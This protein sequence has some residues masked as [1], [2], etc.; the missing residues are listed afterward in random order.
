MLP[1]HSASLGLA[2]FHVLSI[3]RDARAAA[4]ET[5]AAAADTNQAAVADYTSAADRAAPRRDPDKLGPP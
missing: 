4:A 2:R 1:G 3:P 5:K